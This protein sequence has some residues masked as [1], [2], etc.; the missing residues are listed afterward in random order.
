M[1][2]PRAA[3]LITRT[4]VILRV[5]ERMP[6]ARQLVAPAK[7]DVIQ[8]SP[9]KAAEKFGPVTRIY[10]PKTQLWNHGTLIFPQAVPE[11]FAKSSRFSRHWLQS[12]DWI[13][14]SKAGVQGKRLKSLDSRLRGNDR[15][16]GVP[17]IS[18]IPSQALRKPRSGCLEGL[19]RPNAAA[20]RRS[21]ATEAAL[22]GGR[23][24]WRHQRGTA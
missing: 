19:P 1:A 22:L 21:A 15:M 2:S 7:E 12:V 20:T 17:L 18:A 24:L 16:S 13:T 4:F 10:D 23:T 8:F 6:S 3:A 5:C 11:A 9:L 14:S